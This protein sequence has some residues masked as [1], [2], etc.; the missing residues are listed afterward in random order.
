MTGVRLPA[1]VAIFILTVTPLI[2]LGLVSLYSKSTVISA[3][4]QSGRSQKLKPETRKILHAQRMP[5]FVLLIY[6]VFRAEAD[7]ILPSATSCESAAPLVE[8][9]AAVRH[10]VLKSSVDV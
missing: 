7:S 2:L 6:R 5:V 1:R 4:V 9:N 10:H 8:K 3:L